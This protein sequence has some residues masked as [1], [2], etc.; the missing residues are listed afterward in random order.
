MLRPLII[1]IVVCV[2]ANYFSCRLCRTVLVA[3]HL[4]PTLR[5]DKIIRCFA[6]VL[7]IFPFLNGCYETI[8]ALFKEIVWM[9]AVSYYC[10]FCRMFLIQQ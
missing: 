1:D 4:F 7:Y 3:R 5:Q 6:V 10:I 2:S 8:D 9:G